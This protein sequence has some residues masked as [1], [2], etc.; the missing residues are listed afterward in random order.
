MDNR[1][2]YDWKARARD[3]L[4]SCIDWV[5]Y[6]DRFT[7]YTPDESGSGLGTLTS[8]YGRYIQLEYIR[9]MIALGC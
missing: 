4:Q 8:P 1:P 7:V 2:L 5:L 9:R 3:R 6:F